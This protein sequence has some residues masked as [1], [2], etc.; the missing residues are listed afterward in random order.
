MLFSAISA[1]S[2]PLTTRC[3][4]LFS[5]SSAG[6]ARLLWR[7]FMQVPVSHLSLALLAAAVFAATPLHAADVAI[8]V[9]SDNVVNTIQP[10]VYGHFFE[11]I[12]HSANGGIWGEAVW[13]RS[14]E[15]N[16]EGAMGPAAWASTADANIYS[17]TAESR[18]LGGY[19]W[20]DFDL[21]LDVRR[22]ESDAGVRVFFRS[23]G[24]NVFAVTL[25]N[26]GNHTLDR[27]GGG[28]GGRGGTPAATAP[29]LADPAAGTLTANQWHKVRLRMEGTQFQAW[30]D[31]KQIFNAPA[32]QGV[33]PS[34]MIGLGTLGSKAEFKNLLVKGLDGKIF[35]KGPLPTLVDKSIVEKWSL[36]G[37][38]GCIV[39]GA[40]QALNDARCLELTGTTA[41]PTVLQQ[42]GFYLKANDPLEGSLWLNGTAA[43]GATVEFVE[44]GTNAV[45]STVKLAAPGAEWKEFPLSLVSTKN[46]DASLRI[47]FTGDVKVMIDQVSL[48]AKSARDNGGFRPDIY[49]AFAGLKPT[50]MRWP[51]GCYAETYVWKNGIGPQKDRKKGQ[52]AWWEEYDPNALG[53]D[54]YIAL[55]RKIGS[56]P[57]LVIQ[58]GMHQVKPGGSRNDGDPIDTPEEWAPYIK[59]ACEWIEYCNGPATSTWGKVRAA[60]GHPEPYNVKLWEIDNELWRSRVTNPTTYSQAVNL[61]SVAMKKQDPSI[62]IIAHGGNGTDRN[63]NIPVV[64]NAAENFSILSIHHYTQAPQY[65]SGVAAQDALYNDVINLIKGSKNPTARIYVSEWNAQTTD[66]RTGLYA[67]GILNTFEKYGEYITMAGPALMARHVT[68][69]DWD[70]AFIN[71]DSKGW[72]AGPNYVVM[73][74][75][76]DNFAPSRLGA[77]GAA[78]GLNLIATKSQDGSE[79]I[80]KAVNFGTTEP[81]VVTTTVDGSF[82]PAHAAM[83]LVNPGSLQARNSMFEKEVIKPEAAPATVTG[84]QVKFTLPPNSAA[85][86][87]VSK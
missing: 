87:K 1:A 37:G 49:E 24:N 54:E 9:R 45:L 44:D 58:T 56:E 22:T 20:R 11:H 34:G 43:A 19:E 52:Q 39:S 14:F 3:L 10:H 84:N 28:R 69:H 59:E 16:N 38:T 64:N 53:T 17:G 83:Q 65:A 60:N 57:L 35:W 42:P 76:R 63:Y 2:T 72:F 68:A 30:L 61:F 77:D 50:T 82:K 27:V 31:D 13:N 25:G 12:Y 18:I 70:N 75:W 33:A 29:G 36:L 51:G 48:M 81:L 23:K 32:P 41:A 79:V 86:V 5:F 71:F 78:P 26:N 4:T 67:G 80:L 46:A 73:K 74:L 62:T 40:G 6:V 55:S 66:W 21:T 7:F 85:V 8:T 15:Q 47:S